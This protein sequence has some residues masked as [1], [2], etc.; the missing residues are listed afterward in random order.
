MWW[1]ILFG[2][3][4]GY[5][6]ITTNTFVFLLSWI[7]ICILNTHLTL[8]SACLPHRC[9]STLTH[10]E[11]VAMVTCIKGKR[12]LE[13]GIIF[14]SVYQELSGSGNTAF[15]LS[16]VLTMHVHELINHCE[17]FPWVDGGEVVLISFS[18]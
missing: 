6:M 8:R 1:N 11:S 10:T 15:Y 2:R 14:C 13:A 9:C 16:Q 7:Q 5:N 12:V 17:N 18:K 4:V 3:Y